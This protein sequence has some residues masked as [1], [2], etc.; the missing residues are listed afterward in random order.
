MRKK[1]ERFENR[2]SSP[3]F[4]VI[5]SL[6]GNGTSGPIIY[7]HDL[8]PIDR[9]ETGGSGN[10]A[11]EFS[12]QA[13]TKRSTQSYSYR[14]TVS[15]GTNMTG[16]LGHAQVVLGDNNELMMRSHHNF[17]T[18]R[19]VG[20]ITNSTHPEMAIFMSEGKYW[21]GKRKMETTHDSRLGFQSGLPGI[22][23]VND[24]GSIGY[25]E[26]TGTLAVLTSD[27]SGG[28]WNFKVT[29]WENISPPHN[30]QHSESFFSQSGITAALAISSAPFPL[31]DGK[32]PSYKE[33]KRRAVII[34]CDNGDIVCSKMMPHAGY[35]SFIVKKES[36]GTLSSPTSNIF[37]HH[38]TTSYGCEQ[39]PLYGI[40]H[41]VSLN[42]KY[43]VTYAAA[44]YYGSGIRLTITRVSD[45]K[46]LV[47]HINDTYY[48]FQVIPINESDFILTKSGNS[49]S[50]K[51]LFY[52]RFDLVAQFE[53]TTTGA[54]LDIG[55][56]KSG[57]LDSGYYSTNYPFATPIMDRETKIFKAGEAE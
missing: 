33:D 21:I 23:A 4:A 32:T 9:V 1:R 46:V 30:F 35:L 12:H 24:F 26:L 17:T 31:P 27:N 18:Q 57:R 7:N 42:G 47:H 16:H 10:Q 56:V 54:T 8:E 25:N 20:T 43:V 45:G 22:T 29:T 5:S 19:D 28:T 50:G 3:A 48:G 44:Y 51:G 52:Y 2:F 15:S 13:G 11:S 41:V 37:F 34:V 14:Q 36:D 53:S 38:W 39:G 55:S 6:S 40:R 49:D